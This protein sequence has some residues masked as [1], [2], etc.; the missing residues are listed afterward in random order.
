MRQ[1]GGKRGD[2]IKMPNGRSLEGGSQADQEK[3]EKGDAESIKD[4]FLKWWFL[5][6]TLLYK[7]SNKRHSVAKLQN[8]TW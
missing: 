1:K 4:F 8:D 3:G 6:F 5:K 2:S 7:L